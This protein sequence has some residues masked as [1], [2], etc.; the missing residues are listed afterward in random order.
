MDPQN[1]KNKTALPLIRSMAATRRAEA[2]Q[3]EALAELFGE[4]HASA[5]T[6]PTEYLNKKDTAK[7][8]GSSVDVV[9]RDERFQRCRVRIGGRWLYDVSAIDLAIREPVTEAPKKNT[10]SAKLPD[11]VVELRRAGG[12]R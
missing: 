6:K 10:K 3:L 2:E 7:R 9:G 8:Y 5:A 1:P 12:S 11:G 4:T